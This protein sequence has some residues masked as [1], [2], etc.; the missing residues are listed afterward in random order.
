MTDLEDGYFWETVG[1]DA[2]LKAAQPESPADPERKLAAAVLS[3]ALKDAL[4]FGP[5]RSSARFWL[6][7]DNNR[8][9]FWCSV[10]GLNS[11]VV[12]TRIT[13]LLRKEVS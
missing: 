13:R 3:E 10:L 7:N 4:G 11:D 5:D 6:M 1:S 12:R 2:P 8:F 9:P